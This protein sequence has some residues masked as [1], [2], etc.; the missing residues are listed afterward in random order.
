MAFEGLDPVVNVEESVSMGREPEVVV[1][2]DGSL[3]MRDEATGEL[4]HN[5]AGAY[6]EALKN[7]AQ[8]TDLTMWSKRQSSLRVLDVCFG[9]GYNT[10][11]ILDEIMFGEC[12]LEKLSITALEIEQA[13]LRLIARV[14][15]DQRFARLAETLAKE[16]PRLLAGEFGCSSFAVKDRL[17]TL[18]VEVDVRQADLRTAVPELV[19]ESG[20]R[21]DV[22][23]HDPFSPKRVPE[24]WTVDLFKC[25]WS[26]L[27][28]PCGR[29]L[30]YSSATAVRAAFVEAGFDV[31]RTTAVG[32]KSGGTLAVLGDCDPPGQFALPLSSE[33]RAKML[34]GSGCPY[35]DPN[36]NDSRTAIVNRRHEELSKQGAIR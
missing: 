33:E 8:P 20:D 36:F 9:L 13:P 26:L 27:T 35:R 28:K 7:Y 32:G 23:F 10:F 6:T 17:R 18:E 5:R 4:F 24:L 2:E 14:L 19:K 34:T 31:W 16:F 21:Y 12:S 1:T 15:A 30:T 11:V 25:Y 3:S 29:V 22:I